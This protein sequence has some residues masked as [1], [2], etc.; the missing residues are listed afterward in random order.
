MIDEI[1]LKHSLDLV[2]GIII[3]KPDDNTGKTELMIFST[4]WFFFL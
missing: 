3:I 4:H 1:E 2:A